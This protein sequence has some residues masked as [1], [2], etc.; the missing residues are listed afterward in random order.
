MTKSQ[1]N[2]IRGRGVRNEVSADLHGL[3]W[4]RT[5]LAAGRGARHNGPIARHR[6]T[7]RRS[8]SIGCLGKVCVCFDEQDDFVK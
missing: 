4:P 2:W 6:L 3:G 8:A 1:V 7:L 5:R